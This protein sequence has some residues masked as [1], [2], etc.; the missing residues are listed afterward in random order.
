MMTTILHQLRRD[1]RGVAAIE[2]ALIAPILAVLIMGAADVGSAFSRK[3]G[4]EQGAQRAVEKIM[5]TTELANVQ[6]TIAGEVAI[7]ADVNQNQVSVTFPR[8]CSN[9]LMP[10][11]DA[12]ADGLVDR[13]DNGFAKG[14]PCQSS[15]KEAHYIM[16]VVADEYEP[17]FQSVGLGEKLPSGNYRIDAKAGMRTK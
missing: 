12:D 9:R 13:D 11:V 17:M 8:Y 16:I 7:Q 14:E 5:Q 2:L 10:D 15:E 3:L 6:D 1:E 4:L